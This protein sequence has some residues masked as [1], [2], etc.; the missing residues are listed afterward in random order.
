[1]QYHMEHMGALKPRNGKFLSV[2]LVGDDYSF[3]T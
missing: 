2:Y 3:G 1:M